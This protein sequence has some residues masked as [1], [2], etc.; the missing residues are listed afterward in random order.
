M[1]W[2]VGDTSVLSDRIIR[3]EDILA[4]AKKYL[5]GIE[6]V[7]FYENLEADIERLFQYMGCYGK[8][9]LQ[10]LYVTPNRL[11]VGTLLDETIDILKSKNET[12]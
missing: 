3:N 11:K 9:H 8:P 4:A 5:K 2:Q 7:G 12:F 10:N 1:T 6:F